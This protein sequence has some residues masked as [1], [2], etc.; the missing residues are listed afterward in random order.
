MAEEEVQALIEKYD[1]RTGEATLKTRAG[2][3]MTFNVSTVQMRGLTAG[4]IV[5]GKKVTI[6]HSYRRGVLLI[7]DLDSRLF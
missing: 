1:S 6:R 3:I 2:Q 5:S 4:D 7:S